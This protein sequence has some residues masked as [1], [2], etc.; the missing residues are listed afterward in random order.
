MN[1]KVRQPKA[2]KLM[3]LCL[4]LKESE[5]NLCANLSNCSAA[6]YE[7]LNESL[8]EREAYQRCNWIGF[9]LLPDGAKELVL[10]PFQGR[11]A[12]VRIPIGKGVCGIAAQTKK[13]I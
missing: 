8:N 6:L 4:P 12:V 7:T 5:R 1:S 2:L 13:V 3:K 9:Y 11:V 10:G